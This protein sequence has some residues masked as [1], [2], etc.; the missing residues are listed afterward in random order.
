MAQRVPKTEEKLWQ[1]AKW[2]ERI[3]YLDVCRLMFLCTSTWAIYDTIV[4]FGIDSHLANLYRRSSL[5]TWQV[6]RFL[7]RVS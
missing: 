1:N 3:E 2:I 7:L 4:T 5:I 6:L